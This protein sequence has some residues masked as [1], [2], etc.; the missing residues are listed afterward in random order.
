MKI[1]IEYKEPEFMAYVLKKEDVLTASTDGNLGK[2]TDD[3]E[4]PEMLIDLE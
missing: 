4:A 3:W 1:K 2:V